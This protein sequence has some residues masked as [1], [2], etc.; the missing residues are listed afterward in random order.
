MKENF[1]EQESAFVVRQFGALVA[2]G[3][4]ED[5]AQSRLAEVLGERA[6]ERLQVPIPEQTGRSA[7]DEAEIVS[8]AGAAGGSAAAARV[9]LAAACEEARVLALDWWRPIRAFLLYAVFLLAAGVALATYFLA[10]VLPVFSG[11]SRRLGAPHGGVA[12]WILVLDGIRLFGPLVLLA[13]LILLFGA[14]FYAAQRRIAKL[15]PFPLYGRTPWLYGRTGRRYRMLRLLELLEV[16]R[17]AGVPG[18]R[19]LSESMRMV[20]WNPPVPIQI[21]GLPLGTWLEQAVRLGTL[22]AELD[23]QRNRAWEGLQASLELWRDRWIF[24][25]RVVF[26]ALIGYLVIILY[27]PIF[28]IALTQGI[29]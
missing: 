17:Q 27:L 6:V 29:L 5:E 4:T 28:S 19:A 26:Y 21:R 1:E 25:A 14:A 7:I 24:L 8:V 16:L 15:R 9:A 3:L 11:F 22:G 23:W 2:A 13:L 20:R 18:E 10:H 12:G